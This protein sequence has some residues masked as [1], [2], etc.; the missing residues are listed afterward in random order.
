VPPFQAW[1]YRPVYL[2]D[3][4]AM[5]IGNASVE[6]PMWVYLSFTRRADCDLEFIEHPIGIPEKAGSTLTTIAPLSSPG[7]QTVVQG[8]VL[9]A[10]TGSDHLLEIHFD[11][12]RRKEKVDF[13]PQMPIVFRF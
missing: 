12:E 4:L 11:G 1:E 6:E 8:G 13:R 2:P 3:Q 7:S 5:H 10:R 9:S